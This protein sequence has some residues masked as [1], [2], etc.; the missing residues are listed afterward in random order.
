M[1]YDIQKLKDLGF[2]T[3]RKHVKTEFFRYYYYCDKLGMLVWQDMP[4]GNIDGSGSW[5][6]SKMDGG[7]DHKRTQESK[8]NYYKE[9]GEIIENLKFFQSIIIW[10]PFNEDWGQ[11]DTCTVVN[12]TLQHDDSRLINAASGGNHRT[13]SDFVD[14]HPYPSPNY[15][16]KYESLINVI[17]EYGGLGLE[18]KGHTW[19]DDNWGYEVLKDK[20][21]VTNRYI[22]FINMLIDLIPQGISAGIYT[23]TTDVEG[24]INGLMTYDRNET[25]VYDAI[26]E[27]NKKINNFK[28]LFFLT[29]I[30]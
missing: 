13:C 19:K 12:F 9:W 7:V 28:M 1:V 10:T 2:N 16:F 27:Y 4:S 21:E 30:I 20:I 25:K 29:I 26:R 17:G 5:D 24:E 15:F 3:I 22:E 6:S 8:D 11:F 14:I 23:Q 18:I